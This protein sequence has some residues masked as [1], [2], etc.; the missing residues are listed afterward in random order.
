MPRTAVKGKVLADL[1]VEFTKDV[2]GDENLGPSVLMIFAY[3]HI[4]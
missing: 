4:A 2:A 3:S 1:V